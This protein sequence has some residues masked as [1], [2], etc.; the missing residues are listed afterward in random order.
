H[1]GIAEAARETNAGQSGGAIR[2]ACAEIPP[3]GPERTTERESPWN[4]GPA[5]L[6]RRGQL[7]SEGDDAQKTEHEDVKQQP[8]A[9]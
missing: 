5:Q 6:R 4:H 7:R 2:D 9:A 8:A 1:V 3:P